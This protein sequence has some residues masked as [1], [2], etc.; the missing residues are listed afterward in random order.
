[1]GDGKR[2]V[3]KRIQRLRSKVAVLMRKSGILK[4]DESRFL[5]AMQFEAHEIFS[6]E[7]R[8]LFQ[9]CMILF[10]KSNVSSLFKLF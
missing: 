10:N 1:M 6:A 9:K 2:G 3:C 8:V 5:C 4:G 7:L